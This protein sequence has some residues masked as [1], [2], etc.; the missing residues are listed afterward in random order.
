MQCA[1]KDASKQDIGQ[2]LQSGALLQYGFAAGAAAIV[3]IPK[4]NSTGNAVNSTTTGTLPYVAVFPGTWVRYMVGYLRHQDVSKHVQYCTRSAFDDSK[5][6]QPALDQ[7]ANAEYAAY[8][9][10]RQLDDN[11]RMI[12]ADIQRNPHSRH[13]EARDRY[14]S[15]PLL[16]SCI[17]SRIGLFGGIPS[18]FQTNTTLYQ[19]LMFSDGKTPVL[20]AQGNTITG[21][22]TGSR[23]VRPLFSV[24]L[25]VAPIPAIHFLFGVTES[26]VQ[27]DVG[28]AY[29]VPSSVSPG[30][31]ST[32]SPQALAG[33]V[34]VDSKVWTW[35]AGI[36]GTF[37]VASL[38]FG[39][40]GGG[41]AQGAKPPGGKPAVG[42]GG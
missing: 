7:V 42:G 4:P 41:K 22:V 37:D 32:T 14:Y 2:E 39:G 26:Y 5:V 21:L 27:Q 11:T 35:T 28:A 6:E 17:Y 33:K 10:N 9:T 13:E 31:A 24:G 23:S 30:N 1:S 16:G 40:S 38:F 34:G 36:G 18:Q 20:T 25:V 19:P 29:P 8:A 15:H 3:Q 12:L